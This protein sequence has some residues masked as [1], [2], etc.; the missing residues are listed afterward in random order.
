LRRAARSLPLLGHT[1]DAT[2]EPGGSYDATVDRLE[3]EHGEAPGRR[4]VDD[5]RAIRRVES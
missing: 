4:A 3:R 1:P 5:S 2:R